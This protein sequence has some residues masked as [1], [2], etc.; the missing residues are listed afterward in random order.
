MAT[1]NAVNVGLSGATGSGNFVGATS[2]TLITPAI[3]TPSS[4]TLTN[5]TGLPSGAG[6]LCS[7][8]NDS[9]SSGQLGE[10]ISSVVQTG[11]LVTITSSA[12]PQN[13]TSISLTAGDWNVWGNAYFVPNTGVTITEYEA[14]SSSTSATLPN[15]VFVGQITSAAFPASNFT[16]IFPQQRFSLASTTTIYLS[17]QS[18][19]SSGNPKACGGIYARRVR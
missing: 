10:Y 17:V 11:S 7:S 14:W 9:A 19:F 18:S 6:I 12:T 5:C 4:G 1:N 13:V 15:Q 8:T 3:G 2:P 16:V